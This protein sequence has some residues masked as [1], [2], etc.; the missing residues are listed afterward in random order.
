MTQAPTRPVI[1]PRANRGDDMGIGGD[2]R[3]AR[4]RR[5]AYSAVIGRPYPTPARVVPTRY[6]AATASYPLIHTHY[7][8]CLRKRPVSRDP[9]GGL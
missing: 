7:F 1:S 6:A 9:G 3:E 8:L 5:T 4:R 2:D